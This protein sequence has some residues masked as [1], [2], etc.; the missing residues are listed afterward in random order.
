MKIF[1]KIA[2]ALLAVLVVMQFI[3]PDKN[4][5]EGDVIADFRAETKPTQEVEAIL[6]R[7]CFDCHTNNTK[8]PWYAEV[9]P[10]S[11]WLADHVNEGKGHLNLSEWKSYT[12]KRKDH[13]LEELGEEVEK[14]HMPLDSYLW[15]HDEAVL[16]D[17]DIQIIVDWVN[18]ARNNYK[19]AL[20]EE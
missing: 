19:A 17:S 8:Y 10:V 5:Q 7:A 4:L 14:K 1:K 20:S 18:Q 3:R 2:L 6:E 15:V 16:S 11:Y 13:K 9:A 12:V